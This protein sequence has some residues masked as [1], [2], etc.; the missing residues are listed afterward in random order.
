MA[1]W[2]D[3]IDDE[4]KRFIEAQHLFFVSTAPNEIEAGFPN[5]SPKGRN[6]LRVLG[7]NLVGYLDY[8]GSGNETATHLAENGRITL[9]FCSF[10]ATAGITRVYGRG[11]RLEVDNPEIFAHRDAFGADFHPFVRQAFLVE[12]E[13]V[14]TSCGYAVPR[15]DFKEERDT[16][17]RW[18]ERKMEPREMRAGMP[19]GGELVWLGEN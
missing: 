9:M 16:L 10:D 1:T 18:C 4:R 13:K 7:P 12:V 15:M 14:Q 6:L 11:R 2:Y 19:V 8:P 3:H 5:V 17:D